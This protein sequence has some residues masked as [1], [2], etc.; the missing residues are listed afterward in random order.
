MTFESTLRLGAFALVLVMMGVWELVA[1]RL[2]RHISRGRRWATN[3]GLALL[4]VV[5]VRFTMG[6]LAFNAAHWAQRHGWG[7]C[8]GVH[9]PGGLGAVLAFFL[10]DLGIYLQH[11]ATHAWPPLWRLHRVHHADL[12]MDVSTALRF[13]PLELLLS[14]GYK[15]MLVVLLGAAPVAVIA[16]EL[17]LSLGSL[18]THANG[19]MPQYLDSA[20]RWMMVTPAMH[21]IHHSDR[22]IETNSNYG[23][24]FSWWDRIFRTYR[25]EAEPGLIV[26]LKDVPEL[27]IGSLLIWP[28]RNR[29]QVISDSEGSRA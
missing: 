28:F 15:A 27:G 12:D 20:L 3:L 6:A 16:F 2:S 22:P 5:L 19:R 10:L 23:F 24:S 25:S 4:G 13:H 21:T 17:T 14:M 1:P 8:N 18:F 26:G 9:I 11:V 29:P 7:L